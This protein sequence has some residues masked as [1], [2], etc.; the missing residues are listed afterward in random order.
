ME[1]TKALTSSGHKE[2]IISQ[3]VT[4]QQPNYFY[5]AVHKKGVAA[6]DA[7]FT[8]PI[9]GVACSVSG[10]K[11][12][13]HFLSHSPCYLLAGIHQLCCKHPKH[14]SSLLLCTATGLT[15]LLQ[16]SALPV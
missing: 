14:E 12:F 8:R 6:Q 3:V 13:V 9:M 2:R 4:P 16:F 5:G 11:V 1:E 15:T 7:A 10:Y